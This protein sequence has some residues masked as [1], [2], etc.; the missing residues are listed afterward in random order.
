MKQPPNILSKRP[1]HDIFYY[2]KYTSV[3]GMNVFFLETI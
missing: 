3:F 2:L 1:L